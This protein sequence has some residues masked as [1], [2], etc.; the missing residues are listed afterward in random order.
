LGKIGRFKFSDFVRNKIP[1]QYDEVVDIL[2]KE[3]K[4]G[5]WG[6]HGKDKFRE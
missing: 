6:G 1:T 2:D 5:V 4:A 3:D